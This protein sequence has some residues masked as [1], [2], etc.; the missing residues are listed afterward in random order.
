M[1]LPFD[2]CLDLL[3]DRQTYE[4]ALSFHVYSFFKKQVI[5]H[6]DRLFIQVIPRK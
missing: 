4:T 3:I 2:E 5:H 1:N 6:C